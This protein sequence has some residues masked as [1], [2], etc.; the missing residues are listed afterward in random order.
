MGAFGAALL[1]RDNWQAA[2]AI[3]DARSTLL[4]LA[5]CN[6]L[7]WTST[8]RRC[9]QCTNNCQ[10]TVHRFNNRDTEYVTGNRSAQ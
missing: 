2:G 6:E 7:R 3:A 4:T 10:L 8:T 5:Q 1:S 9:G